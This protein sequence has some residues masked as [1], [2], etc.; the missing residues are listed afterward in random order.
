MKI[1]LQLNNKRRIVLINP[2]FQLRIIGYFSSIALLI[3]GAFYLGFYFFVYTMTK[4][5]A[6]MDFNNNHQLF[7]KIIEQQVANANTIIIF[8]SIVVVVFL[9]IMGM[10]ISHRIAGPIYRI[11][12]VL[13]TCQKKSDFQDIQ[14]RDGDYFPELAEQ[15]NNFVKRV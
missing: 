11:C 15:I 3:V 8:V 2:N 5:V 7:N 6:E 9:M 13:S 4:Q 1:L 10:V 12:S 14:L